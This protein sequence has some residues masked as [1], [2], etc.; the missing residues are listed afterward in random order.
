MSVMTNLDP[1]KINDINNDPEYETKFMLKDGFYKGDIS[2][3]KK[4]DADFETEDRAQFNW[5]NI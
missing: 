1:E 2:K 4:I 5:K 3:S